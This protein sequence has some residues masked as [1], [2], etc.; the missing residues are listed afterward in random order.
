MPNRCVRVTAELCCLAVFAAGTAHASPLAYITNSGDGTVSV[1]DTDTDTIATTVTSTSLF[2]A[3]VAL[4]NAGTRAYITSLTSSPPSIRV[5]DTLTNTYITSVPVPVF[6]GTFFTNLIVSPTQP[7]AYLG[8]IPDQI[9]PLDLTTNALGAPI[10]VPVSGGDEIRHVTASPD[11]ATLYVSKAPSAEVSVIDVASGLETGTIPG[12]GLG[13]LVVDPAGSFVYGVN[14]SLFGASN[15]IVKSSTGSN[16]VVDSEDFGVACTGL[17]ALTIDSTG[18][19]VYGSCIATS[20]VAAIDTATLAQT[21]IPVGLVPAGTSLTPDDA[22]LYVA[23]DGDD[24]VSVIATA[25]NT[26]VDTI[27]VG[28]GPIA[29]GDFIGPD[30]VCGNGTLEPG[31]GCDD[32]NV[33]DGDGCSSSCYVVL[34]FVVSPV[35][36][37]RMTIPTGDSFAT[38]TIKVKVRNNDT[39]ARDVTMIAISPN[40]GSWFAE[41][42]FGAG[43][44]NP[45]TVEAGKAITGTVAVTAVANT[46]FQPNAE[47]PIRCTFTVTAYPT[48]AQFTL[49]SNASNDVAAFDVDVVDEGQIEMATMHETTI[50]AIKP[51]KVKIKEGGASGSKKLKFKAGNADYLPAPEAAANH[52]VSVTAL[53]GSCPVTTA[54]AAT[55]SGGPTADVEGGATVKGE[56]TMTV[57]AAGMTSPNKKSPA[58]CVATVTANGPAGDMA[59]ENNTATV[60]IDVFDDNDF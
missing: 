21:P 16:S 33:L 52:T 38:K 20:T 29:V 1:I 56:V 26:V 54:G 50:S 22:K 6:A 19:M 49:D 24:T 7:Y 47:A 30:F 31:E 51:A 18:S 55:V 44:S 11:G 46:V 45:V 41:A 42:D 58:R 59:A 5:L 27:S 37:L 15:V 9:Y 36:P 25:S 23:N 43:I 8:T 53:D 2:P 39:V 32:G 60:T 4:N 12:G 34:D 14:E 57:P 28:D 17:R 35:K 40:C 13:S 10:T 3:H 48:P